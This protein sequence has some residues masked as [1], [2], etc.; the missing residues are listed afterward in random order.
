MT[1]IPTSKYQLTLNNELT[2]VRNK[3][4]FELKQSK[5]PYTNELALLL[6]NNPANEWLDL[7]AS[8]LTPEQFPRYQRLIQL[9]AALCQIEIGQ[10]GYCC[11]CEAPLSQEE[12]QQ[13]AA[14]QRCHRCRPKN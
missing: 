12:L 11:D 8:K 13:D 4:L 14:T 1:T 10:F 9:E 5:H 6:E 2:L 7:I 3:F